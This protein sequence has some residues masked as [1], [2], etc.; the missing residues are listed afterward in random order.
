MRIGM[1]VPGFSAHESDWAIPTLQNLAISLAREHDIHVFSLRYPSRQEASN[2]WLSSNLTHHPVGGGQ[3]YRLSSRSIWVQTLR[4]IYRQHQKT[5]FSLFHAFWADEPGLVAG[6]AGKWLHRP[7]IVSSAGGEFVY[8]PDIRYG[9][10]A[11]NFRRAVVRLALR[12]ADVVTAGSRYQEELCRIQRV[13]AAKVQRL[14]LGV[15]TDRFRPVPLPA[16]P[17]TLVQAASLTPV[18]N[19]RLLI[20]LLARVRARVP[21]VRLLIAGGGPLWAELLQRAEQWQLDRAIHWLG[22]MAFPDMPAVYAQAHL[23]VQTSRHESQGMAVL[24]A[25]ACGRPVVGTPVG[26]ARELALLPDSMDPAGFAATIAQL[27]SD[28]AMLAQMSALAGT[29]VQEHYALGRVVEWFNDL[30]DRVQA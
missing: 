10:S 22:E 26:V 27:W 12:L 8:L 18:K 17:L 11:S 5:P 2:T 25:M 24:E 4:T 14:P 7:V 15:E 3:R 6:L 21:D 23:Y 16:G 28:R 30:Y 13:S 29:V 19:Q 9:T 20:D 1:V